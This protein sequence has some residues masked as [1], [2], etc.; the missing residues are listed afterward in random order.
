MK[1][2]LTIEVHR[3]AERNERRALNALLATIRKEYGR[4]VDPLSLVLSMGLPKAGGF[5]TRRPFSLS[6]LMWFAATGEQTRG[7]VDADPDE[8]AQWLT[9]PNPGQDAPDRSAPRKKGH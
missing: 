3:Q 2:L 4:H 9:S 1:N 6:A 5:V 7:Q 8:C